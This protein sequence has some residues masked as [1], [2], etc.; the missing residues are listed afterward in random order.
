M[1]IVEEIKEAQPKE[2]MMKWMGMVQ[3][4]KGTQKRVL[5]E[6]LN[7]A[8]NT[9]FGKKN[10]FEEIDSVEAFQK[11][12]PLTEYLD[13]DEMIDRMALGEENILFP[14]LPKYFL[15]TSGTTGKSKKIPES[16]LSCIAKNNVV[17]LRT[18]YDAIMMVKHPRFVKWAVAHGIDVKNINIKEIMKHYRF[19]SMA[20]STQNRK[21]E[22][23]IDVV[24]ASGSTLKN[25]GLTSSLAYPVIIQKLRDAEAINYLTMLFAMR[26]EDVHMIIGN[27]SARFKVRIDYVKENAEMLI[28][29]MRSGTI[30]EKV[31]LTKEEREQITP[32]FE[33]APERADKL[34][35]LLDSGRE[36]FIP[37]NY[38]PNIF[39]C[40]F[41]LS[42]TLGITI[43][44]LYPLLPDDT[45]YIDVGYG[46]SEAKINIP[47]KPSAKDGTLAIASAFYEFKDMETEKVY[48]ADNVEIGKEYDL[49]V[50][51]FG[52]FYRYDMHDI[53][54]VNGFNGN[55]PDIEF[56]TKAGEVLNV[57]QEKLPAVI[58]VDFLKE[59]MKQ[60]GHAL[61]Q[62]QI[63]QNL[64]EKYYTIYI[65]NEDVIEEDMKV[66]SKKFDD[67]LRQKL[68]LYAQ[69]RRFNYLNQLQ[70]IEMKQGWQ[71]SLYQEKISSGAPLA[72]IKLNALIKKYPDK[73]WILEKA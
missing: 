22:S 31:N 40:N 2:K 66:L 13:Y 29:D 15:S 30:S 62:A 12:M 1:T 37:K 57:A 28:Q 44:E 24:Y 70:M 25:S 17:E 60:E 69:V 54:R 14:G 16:E 71:D 3:D 63:Y 65:E 26:T 52:G 36:N 9:E 55:T 38:W 53:V 47:Y 20:S 59:F 23:G 45:L 72:Q 34:Q 68:E 18:G 48:T 67:M 19:F 42:G 33:A 50:T 6:I 61:R 21:T 11:A 73:E 46:A 32:L 7:E 41:W 51:T 43:E 39:E 10:H 49:I 4:C 8:K 64:E 56:I 58:V 5:M 27:N 35:E